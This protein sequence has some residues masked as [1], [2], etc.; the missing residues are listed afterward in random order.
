MEAKTIPKGLPSQARTAG[1][2]LEGWH[3]GDRTEL[4]R[5][6]KREEA[7]HVMHVGVYDPSKGHEV[8]KADSTFPGGG[9]ET[10]NGATVTGKVGR[11]LQRTV[12]AGWRG[13]CVLRRTRKGGVC[14]QAGVEGSSMPQG[15]EFFY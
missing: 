8:W 11:A 2:F 7:P 15:I 13:R 3:H 5:Q 1:G 14:I 12:A 9:L 4:A 10:R 6:R